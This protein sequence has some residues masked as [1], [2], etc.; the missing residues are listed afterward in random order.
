M[1]LLYE[2]R[3]LEFHYYHFQMNSNV[4]Q[5]SN[6][7]VNFVRYYIFRMYYL[8]IFHVQNIIQALL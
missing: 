6:V 1:L 3:C 5:I 2:F 4:V 7:L 8:I